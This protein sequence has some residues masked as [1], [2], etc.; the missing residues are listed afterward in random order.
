LAFHSGPEA[1]HSPPSSAE[2][3]EWVELYL[4][5]SNTPSWRG[6][7]LGGAQGQFYLYFLGLSDYLKLNY[8][9]LLLSP[10]KCWVTNE[11]LQRTIMWKML[12]DRACRTSLGR[13][14]R[15]AHDASVKWL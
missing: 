4:H 12:N 3:K 14:Q 15:H 13:W 2:V 7:R 10:P 5:S 11:V 8:S 1:N 9:S 6:A